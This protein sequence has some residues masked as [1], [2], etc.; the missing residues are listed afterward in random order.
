[1]IGSAAQ[2]L[3]EKNIRPQSTQSGLTSK[4]THATAT[5]HKK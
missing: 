2:V 5:A 3:T 4:Q 1:V